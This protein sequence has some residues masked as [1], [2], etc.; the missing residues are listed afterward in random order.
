M[1]RGFL[2]K[3]LSVLIDERP[4][5]LSEFVD[6]RIAETKRRE[7]GLNV[8]SPVFSLAQIAVLEEVTVVD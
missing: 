6:F 5:T 7:A 3:R 4:A 8:G 1:Q 2:S